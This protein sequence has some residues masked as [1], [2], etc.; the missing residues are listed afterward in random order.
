VRSSSELRA[1]ATHI[2]H[3][4][5][6]LRQAHDLRRLRVGWT[7]W[8]V[9]ARNVATFFEVGQGRRG[10]IRAKEFFESGSADLAKW[11]AAKARRLET[12][13]PGLGVLYGQASRAVAHLSWQRVTEGEVQAPSREVTRL[14]LRLWSDFVRCLGAPHRERFLE[15]WKALHRRPQKPQIAAKRSRGLD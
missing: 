14:L 8:Y 2:A 15:A 3:D 6:L 9:L 11:R 13:P 10:D 5:M 7:A 12:A 4:V 1:A